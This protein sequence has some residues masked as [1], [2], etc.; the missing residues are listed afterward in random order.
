MQHAFNSQ[1]REIISRPADWLPNYD[2][3]DKSKFRALRRVFSDN[4][5][6]PFVDVETVAELGDSFE[7]YVSCVARLNQEIKRPKK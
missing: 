2:P 6:E 3:A 4:W 1:L 7:N 5:Q